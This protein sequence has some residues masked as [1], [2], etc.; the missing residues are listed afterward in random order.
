MDVTPDVTNAPGAEAGRATF[1]GDD[2]TTASP[3]RRLDGDIP[4]AT[5]RQTRSDG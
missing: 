2:P 5:A 4:S 3:P 1:D